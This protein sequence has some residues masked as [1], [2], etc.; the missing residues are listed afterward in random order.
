MI[1]RLDAAGHALER[2]V[3]AAERHAR[4][5]YFTPEPLIRFVFDRLEDIAVRPGEGCTVLDPACGSGRFLLAAAARWGALRL[6]GWETD[7]GAFA[8]ARDALPDADLRTGSFLDARGRG[9]A[10][11]VIGNPPYLRDRGAKRDVYVDFVEKA[12]DHLR[13]GGT[14]ALV[15]STAWLDVEYGA[16][17]RRALRSRAAIRRL[18]ESSSERWFPGAK[19]HTMV[20]VAQRTDDEAERERS[21]VHFAVA[22]APLPAPPRTARVV[23]Q[24]SLPDGPWGVLLRASDAYLTARTA[25]G[26]APL[27]D[28]FDVRRGFTTN[29]NRFFYPPPAAQRTIEPA[30]LEPV[31]RSPKRARGVRAVAEQLPDRVFT[32]GAAAGP[33]AA[34]W[35]RRHHPGGAPKLGTRVSARQFLLKGYADR[36]RQPLFDTELLCDQQLYAVRPKADVGAPEATAGL[37]NSTWMHLALEYT[38]RVNFGEGVLWLGLRDARAR[39]R[40]PDLRCAP[41]AALAAL[42]E[43]FDA[44]P[45]TPVP[46]VG[47]LHADARWGPAVERLDSIVA[48]L[49]G[50]DAATMRVLRDELRARTAVRTR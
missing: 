41:P 33:G 39:M 12:L 35:V 42:A 4:G 14:L 10:D 44:L 45:S 40:I 32:G 13:P 5:Q 23:R 30:A 1:P 24:G 50:V 18:V 19:V 17:V 48:D 26:T 8:I 31:F 46:P 9:D 2:D 34:A 6:R 22:D 11:L 16:A 21:P 20:L 37:F 43:A 49:L 28:L 3:P 38:G 25:P 15:L 29:N 36:F 27:G 47:E 7:P